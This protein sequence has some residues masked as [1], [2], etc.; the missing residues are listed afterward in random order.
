L[1]VGSIGGLMEPILELIVTF[2]KNYLLPC[3]L[4]MKIIQFAIC[5]V[6]FVSI[7]CSA[8]IVRSK[9]V[10]MDFQKHNPC[11]STGKP[12]GKCP[13]YIKDHIVPLACG[14]ADSVQNLQWQTIAD[15]KAKDRWERKQCQDD[16]KK[17][18]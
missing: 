5:L 18:R 1:H 2:I 14:G 8:E 12:S 15:A 13:G 17:A 10:L 7:N 4:F 9:A 11:P 16:I 6:C 3:E